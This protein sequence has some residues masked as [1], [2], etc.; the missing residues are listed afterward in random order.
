[1]KYDAKKHL[2]NGGIPLKYSTVNLTITQIGRI[3]NNV[4]CI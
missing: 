1:M 2:D 4:G 3:T